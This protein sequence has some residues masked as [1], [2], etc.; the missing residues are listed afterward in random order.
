[1]RPRPSIAQ[2]HVENLTGTRGA[3]R[4]YPTTP[5]KIKAWEPKVAPR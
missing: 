2:P 4:T 3:F 1:M 5:N